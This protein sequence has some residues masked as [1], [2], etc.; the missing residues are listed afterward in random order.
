MIDEELVR[1]RQRSRSIIMAVLLGSFALLT[2][3]IAMAKITAG[4]A[5]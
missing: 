5:G 4:H 3:L 2:F 1:R